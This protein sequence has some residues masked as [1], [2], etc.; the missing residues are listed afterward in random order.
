[1]HGPHHGGGMLDDTIRRRHRLQLRRPAKPGCTQSFITS[2][3]QSLLSTGLDLAHLPPNG[4]GKPVAMWAGA[5]ALPLPH[6]LKCNVGAQLQTHH[7]RGSAQIAEALHQLG[8]PEPSPLEASGGLSH[9]Q[10]V[11]AQQSRS[12]RTT[13]FIWSSYL[14]VQSPVPIA[15]ACFKK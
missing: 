3:V 8:A 10:S 11:E 15:V 5:T 6:H 13:F 1:M 12:T 9:L 4:P 2:S 7:G 14:D